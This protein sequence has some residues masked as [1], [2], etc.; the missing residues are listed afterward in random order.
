MILI[1]LFLILILSC[2]II[3]VLSISVMCRNSSFCLSGE[4]ACIYCP[5]ASD[6]D[7]LVLNVSDPSEH[8]FE[9]K[10]NKQWSLPQ[11]VLSDEKFLN[12][13]IHFLAREFGEEEHVSLHLSCFSMNT[14][15][16]M[17]HRRKGRRRCS[18]RYRRPSLRCRRPRGC[19]KDN[20]CAFI[21]DIFTNPRCSLSEPRCTECCQGNCK[22]VPVDVC[23]EEF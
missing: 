7:A 20:T 22:M 14:L 19:A 23:E 2:G 4:G 1:R 17:S 11:P 21:E 5:F 18:F 10:V 6:R 3:P 15:D 8:G 9:M 13:H 16:H 12:D